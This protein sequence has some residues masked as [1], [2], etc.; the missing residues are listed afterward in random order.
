MQLLPSV[1]LVHPKRQILLLRTKNATTHGMQK[2]FWCKG[3]A[4]SQV[5]EE[6]Q[7]PLFDVYERE[8]VLN[9]YFD[10][11]QNIAETDYECNFA[12]LLF[13][14][15]KTSRM[16]QRQFFVDVPADSSKEEDDIT[17]AMNKLTQER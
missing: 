11:Y 3:F 4:L 15:A 1:L 2:G 8:A 13:E 6:S 12:G 5:F 9:S 7:L 16:L 14:I 17:V 10:R